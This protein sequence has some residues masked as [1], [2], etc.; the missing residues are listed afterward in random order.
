MRRKRKKKKTIL[1]ETSLSQ[2]KQ[3]HIQ[4]LGAELE[5]RIVVQII[6]RRIKTWKAAAAAA[7]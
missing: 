6:H 7:A 3:M 1:I 4:A 5:Q 2:R